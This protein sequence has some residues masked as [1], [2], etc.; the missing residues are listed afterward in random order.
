[1]V[2]NSTTLPTH[3]VTLLHHGGFTVHHYENDS[4]NHTDKS[5]PL[6]RVRAFL[7]AG[8]VVREEHAVKTRRVA[9]TENLKPADGYTALVKAHVLAC[10]CPSGGVV[11]PMREQDGWYMIIYG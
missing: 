5:R 7:M 3:D 6:H 10:M 8:S 4:T 11:L 9:V 1:M 2:W